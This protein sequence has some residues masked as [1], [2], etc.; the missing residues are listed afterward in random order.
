MTRSGPTLTHGQGSLPGRAA[1][2]ADR[3]ARLRKR[4]EGGHY[5]LEPRLIAD[6]ILACDEDGPCGSSRAI[7]LALRRPQ[8]SKD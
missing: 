4:I 7:E 8:A 2:A 5:P 3:I 6:A 1:I